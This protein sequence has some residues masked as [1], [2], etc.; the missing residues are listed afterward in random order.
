MVD[1]ETG[2]PSDDKR[3]VVTL[4]AFISCRKKR[5]PDTQRGEEVAKKRKK[6]IDNYVTGKLAEE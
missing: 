1:F 5:A 2:E 6:I 4:A 3:R